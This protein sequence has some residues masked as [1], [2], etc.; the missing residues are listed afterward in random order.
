MFRM[1]PLVGC[2]LLALPAGGAE[3]L[4]RQLDEEF[5]KVFE[6]A[7][8]SVVVIE[9]VK[10][11]D[12]EIAAELFD[13]GLR[14]PNP[15]TH[16]EASGM[17]I[18]G[19]SVVT[20]WHVIQGAKEIYVKTKSHGRLKAYVRASDPATDIAVLDLP[21][22]FYMPLPTIEWADSDQVRV[23]QLVCAIGVPYSMEYSFTVGVVSGKGRSGLTPEST[24][25][26]DYLQTS[27]PINPGNSGGPLLDVEGR[28]IGMNTLINGHNRG[29]SFA[30]PSNL[31]R[32]V[33]EQLLKTG[34]VSRPALGV[35]VETL[36]ESGLREHIS[37]P[38]AVILTIEPDSPAYKSDLRPADV[39]TAIDGV[40]VATAREFRQQVLS[41]KIGQA[42]IL[43]VQ[44]GDKNLEI[45]VTAGE[46]PPPTP[47]EA[48]GAVPPASA[49]ERMSD[50]M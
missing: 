44:R 28:V 3:S 1:L 31:V 46:M 7:A 17:I 23:G 14:I 39:V 6:K 32:D 50:G 10:K 45:T 11:P 20:N 26:E 37:G 9:T 24:P 15:S 40:P 8:P 41:K 25:Y 19:G 42:V 33:A 38:G 49:P 5:V 47:P 13:S 30:I 27:V 22:D 35:R 36:S 12:A 29:L 4:L 16:G 18:P 48:A 34:T 2:L 21:Y 43:T